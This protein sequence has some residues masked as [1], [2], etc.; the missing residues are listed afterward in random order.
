MDLLIR[1]INNDEIQVIQ[2][3]RD[4]NDLDSTYGMLKPIK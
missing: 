1:K 4:R 3:I 2:K